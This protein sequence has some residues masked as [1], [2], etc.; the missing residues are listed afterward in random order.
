MLPAIRKPLL[1]AEATSTSVSLGDLLEQ[2]E[3]IRESDIPGDVTIYDLFPDLS[4]YASPSTHE[5]RGERRA[6]ESSGRLAHTTRLMDIKPIII[7]SVQPGQTRRPDA[8]WVDISFAF[9][10]PPEEDVE[11]FRIDAAQFPART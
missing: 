2:D 4:L 11:V 5:G 1:S 10:H 7:S 6:D 9:L 8:K 3:R